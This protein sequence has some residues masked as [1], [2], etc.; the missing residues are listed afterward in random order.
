M[1]PGYVYILTNDAMPGLVKI[2]RTSRDVDLR[3]S[4]LWQTGVPQRFE[5][6]WSCKTPDCVQLEAYVHGD[7]RKYRVSKSREFFKIDEFEAQKRIRFWLEIQAF[8]LVSEFFGGE[9]GTASISE[10]IACQG[11]RRISEQTGERT[12]TISYAISL[13]TAEELAPAITR[14]RESLEAEHQE[15]LDRLGIPENERWSY[16]DGV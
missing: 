9:V 1:N 10:I 6:F 16:F 3:A 4:E 11:V 14:A 15:S 13:L 2:G 7:L 12:G 5:V 8:D